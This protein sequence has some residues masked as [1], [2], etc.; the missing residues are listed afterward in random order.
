[1]FGISQI[2][3]GEI[4]LVL[5]IALLVF[6]PKKLPDLGKSLGRGMRDFKRGISGDD[7]D[8]RREEERQTPA[9]AIAPPSAPLETSSKQATDDASVR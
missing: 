1:M 3:P 4:V 8:E 9:A 5:L 2:G 6:G 7:E